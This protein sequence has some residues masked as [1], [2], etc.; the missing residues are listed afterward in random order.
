[1]G[2]FESDDWLGI[3]TGGA[4][5]AVMGSA[6]GRQSETSGLGA[7]NPFNL[8]TSMFAKPRGHQDPGTRDYP[9]PVPLDIVS[10]ATRDAAAE[11]Q[12]AALVPG[13]NVSPIIGRPFGDVTESPGLTTEEADRLRRLTS[14]GSLTIGL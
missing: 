12:A 5:P 3:L 2:S 10:P 1:M 7:S 9:A 14:Q 6:S 8:L 13:T 11:Q 4:V